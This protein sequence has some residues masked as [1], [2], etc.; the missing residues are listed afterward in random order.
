MLCFI[1]KKVLL[2]FLKKYIHH[3]QLITSI[4]DEHEQIDDD[5]MRSYG[6]FSCDPIQTVPCFF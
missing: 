2:F 4:E 5:V 3:I 1:E 6:N